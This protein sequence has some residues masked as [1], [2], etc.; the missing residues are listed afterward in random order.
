MPVKFKITRDNLIIV[1]IDC[2]WDIKNVVPIKKRHKM[3]QLCVATFMS[4]PH[5]I[6]LFQKST[7]NNH[8]INNILIQ[9]IQSVKISRQQE[10]A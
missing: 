1:D 6:A 8:N 7:K 4:F 9:S 3:D 2:I 10:M 5:I